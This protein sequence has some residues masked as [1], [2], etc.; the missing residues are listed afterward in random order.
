MNVGLDFVII[1]Y[2]KEIVKWTTRAKLDVCSNER[3]S[4]VVTFIILICVIRI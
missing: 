4:I 2:H 1:I 3:G